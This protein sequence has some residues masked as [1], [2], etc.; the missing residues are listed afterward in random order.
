MNQNDAISLPSN[1]E[2]K[3]A[4]LGFALLELLLPQVATL[5]YF[6]RSATGRT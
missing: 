1:E 4:V 5:W 6:F 2:P 3:N